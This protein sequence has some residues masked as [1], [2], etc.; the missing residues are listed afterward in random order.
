MKEQSPEQRLEAL[1]SVFNEEE[2]KLFFERREKERIAKET[3]QQHADALEALQAHGLIT[4]SAAAAMT[5]NPPSTAGISEADIL[6]A[7]AHV[8]FTGSRH[9]FGGLHCNNSV[10]SNEQIGQLREQAIA[11]R[12]TDESMATLVQRAR[13]IAGPGFGLTYQLL[14]AMLAVLDDRNNPDYLINEAEG[15]IR[16]T[17]YG[18]ARQRQLEQAIQNV[19]NSAR[20][21]NPKYFNGN[22]QIALPAQPRKPGPKRTPKRK[23]PKNKTA[24]C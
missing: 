13:K 4:E 15:Q 16:W 9:E 21:K 23:K 20:G 17:E 5:E 19:I 1:L 22:E 11:L 24:Y 12:L 10:M 6:R 3:A 18:L 8:G 2:R 14:Q 7:R